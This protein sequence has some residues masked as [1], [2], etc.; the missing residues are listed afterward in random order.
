AGALEGR[1]YSELWEVFALAGDRRLNGPLVLDADPVTPGVQELSHP[2]VTNL[3]NYLETEARLAVR[4]RIGTRLSFAFLGTLSWRTDHVISFAEGGGAL[5]ASPPRRPRCETDDNGLV[6][7][8][9][10]EVNPLHV[11]KIDLVGHR[12][13][14]EQGRGYAL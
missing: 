5:P 1:G 8:G 12:Y 14:A 4:A 11:R 3:E 10:E 9:T 2:G 7:P 6:N 13:R